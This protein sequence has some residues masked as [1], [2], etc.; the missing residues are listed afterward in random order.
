MQMGLIECSEYF[1]LE[2]HIDV[3]AKVGVL[4][5]RLSHYIV[6]SKGKV[7]LDESLLL[8]LLLAGS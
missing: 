1:E 2:A 6:S 3:H 4:A 7:L 8:G 5:Y